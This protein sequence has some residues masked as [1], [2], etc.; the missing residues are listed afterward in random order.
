MS[1]PEPNTK[2]PGLPETLWRACRLRCPACG[3]GNVAKNWRETHESCSECEFDLRVEGGFYLGSIYVNY[4][5]IAVLLLGIGMPAVW[6]EY[7]SP[8]TAITVGIVACVVL[9][10]W[11][12]RYA[13]SLWLGLGY[14]VDHTV[15]ARHAAPDPAGD[16]RESAHVDPDEPCVDGVCPMCHEPFP[17]AESRAKSWATCAYCGEKILLIPIERPVAERNSAISGG[18]E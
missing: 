11:F 10:V 4:G 13:R 16:N 3:R 12:W 15:R 17:F 9:T 1:S 2:R 8:A 5:V 7:V 18:T 6:L 14:Y